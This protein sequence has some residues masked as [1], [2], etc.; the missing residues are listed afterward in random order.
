M[1]KFY[2]RDYWEKRLRASF[3]SDGVGYS[4]L[5]K[6]YNDWLYKIRRHVFLHNV[7]I[8]YQNFRDLRVLDVGSGN[9]F[10]LEIWKD[11]GVK[12]AVGIDITEISVRTL[13]RKF[14]TYQF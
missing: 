4:V 13:S 10:Y 5:G 6:N 3:K 8:I 9:G 12:K 7:S 14:P 1:T 2:P 11:L